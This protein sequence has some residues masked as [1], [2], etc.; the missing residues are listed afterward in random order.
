MPSETVRSLRW[1]TL[2]AWGG[3]LASISVFFVLAR[4]LEPVEFG[5]AALAASAV[6]IV[7]VLVDQGFGSAVVQRKELTPSMTWSALALTATAGGV[8]TLMVMLAA[9]A[10]AAAFDNEGLT[11]VLRILAPSLLFAG[12]ASVPGALL[13]RKLAFRALAMVGLC[14]AVGSAAVGLTAALLGAGA[15]SMALQG[16]TSALIHLVL[17]VLFSRS[18]LDRPV[19]PSWAGVRALSGFSSKV[20]LNQVFGTMSRRSDD[21]IVGALLGPTALAL[22][23]ILY[24]ILTVPLDL[25]GTVVFRVAFAS[26]SRLDRAETARAA[27]RALSALSL[28]IFPVYVLL[29]FYM[30]EVLRLIGGDKYVSGATTGRI[31]VLAGMAQVYAF[32]NAAFAMAA[33]RPGVNTAIDIAFIPALIAMFA[34]TAPFGLTTLAGGY[35]G[36][37]ILGVLIVAIVYQRVGL[38]GAAEYLKPVVRPLLA[39]AAMVAGLVLSRSL[40]GADGAVAVLATAAAGTLVYLLAGLLLA[41]EAAKDLRGALIRQVS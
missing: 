21:V 16:V 19:R 30:P 28:A 38:V 29:S 20:F 39:A 15:S 41:R 36:I 22:Y 7:G 23:A 25:I 37:S 11:P 1:A 9:P 35:L 34:I 4:L 2:E 31:L 5:T 10:V 18:A 12:L 26:W 24:R 14:A 33:G 32:V 3:R 13:Q 17:V 27:T 8:M 40:M 6:A